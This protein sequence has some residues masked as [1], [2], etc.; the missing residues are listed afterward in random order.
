[1][2]FLKNNPN[3]SVNDMTNHIYNAENGFAVDLAEVVLNVSSNGIASNQSVNSFHNSLINSIKNSQSFMSSFDGNIDVDSKQVPSW[4]IWLNN[5]TNASSYGM[6]VNGGSM[7]LMKGGSL[8]LKYYA[9][10]WNG[11]SRAAINTYKFTKLGT[12][13]GYGTSFVGAGFGVYNY[14]VSDKS[15]GDKGA[16]T[17]S[18][19]SA[20]LTCFPATTPVG[21]GIGVMDAAGGFNDFYQYLDDNQTLYNETGLI[22]IPSMPMSNT[23]MF[24]QLKK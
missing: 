21:I 13:I 24:L 22:V 7:R 17:V 4:A 2:N 6:Y 15:W 10:G 23:P 19:V 1:M 20:G 9:S 3:A 11:G 18:L 5:A 12:N 14:A 8:S 16:L